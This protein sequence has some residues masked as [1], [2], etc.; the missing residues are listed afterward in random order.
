MLRKRICNKCTKLWVCDKVDTSTIN[1]CKLG[2][3]LVAK[4]VIP[5]WKTGPIHHFSGCA[6]LNSLSAK[7]ICH[8]LLLLLLSKSVLI[9]CQ[10]PVQLSLHSGTA[11]GSV[12]VSLENPVTI[13][14]QS[15]A[16]EMLQKLWIIVGTLLC[17]L[18][19]TGQVARVWS[20][21]WTPKIRARTPAA[22]GAKLILPLLLSIALYTTRGL[23]WIW[24]CCQ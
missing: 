16:P 10:R 11:N 19:G 20:G 9:E 13:D 15:K 7:P 4:E 23:P 8:L 17:N 12:S 6:S 2:L 3:V 18:Y 5:S 22:N 21:S 1:M 14:I 24:S